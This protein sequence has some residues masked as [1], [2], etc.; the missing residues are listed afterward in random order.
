MTSSVIIA[1]AWRGPNAI[2]L[3]R[4]NIT[5]QTRSN[6]MATIRGNLSMSSN[7]FVVIDGIKL[8]GKNACHASENI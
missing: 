7:H 6:M 5:D 1:V 3:V 8:C 4:K 2:N